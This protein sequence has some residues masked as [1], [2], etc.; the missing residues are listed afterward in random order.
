MSEWMQVVEKMR[1][2]AKEIHRLRRLL[3]RPPPHTSNPRR[4]W[5]KIARLDDLRKNYWRYVEATMRQ[6]KAP[7]EVVFIV[8]Q[9]YYYRETWQYV[10]ARLYIDYQFNHMMPKRA[11]QKWQRQHDL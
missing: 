5:Q 7:E 2:C 11:L 10:A 1:A 9:H 4:T 6:K 3:R 8:R